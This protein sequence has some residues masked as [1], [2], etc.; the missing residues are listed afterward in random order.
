MNAV[1]WLRGVVMKR[2]LL[3]VF[4]IGIVISLPSRGRAQDEAE[5]KAVRFVE[6]VGGTVARDPKQKG[7]PVLGVNLSAKKVLDEDLKDLV[8]LTSL[9]TLDVSFTPLTDAGLKDLARLGQLQ[10]LTLTGTK[11]SEAGL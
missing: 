4:G 2:L 1:A 8:G 11:I 9:Q 6:K 7:N 10:T 5:A 3:A